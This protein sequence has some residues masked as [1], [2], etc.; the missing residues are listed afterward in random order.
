MANQFQISVIQNSNGSISN[1]Y[2]DFVFRMSQYLR[3]VK[4]LQNR[5]TVNRMYSA[6]TTE[7]YLLIDEANDS[8]NNLTQVSCKHIV[9]LIFTVIKQSHWFILTDCSSRRKVGTSSSRNTVIWNRAANRIYAGYKLKYFE[10]NLYSV[11]EILQGVD[12]TASGISH[13]RSKTE[14]STDWTFE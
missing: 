13:I 4:I 10:E 11:H 1:W 8:L 6:K 2:Y 7:N 14:N 5:E 9:C 12:E 3:F